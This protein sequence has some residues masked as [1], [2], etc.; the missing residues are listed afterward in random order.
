MGLGIPKLAARFDRSY[1]HKIRM[2]LLK[3][4]IQFNFKC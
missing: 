2:A 3:K 4:S 1:T